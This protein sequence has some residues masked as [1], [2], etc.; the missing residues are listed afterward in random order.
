MRVSVHAAMRKARPVQDVPP[1][2]APGKTSSTCLER[3]AKNCQYTASSCSPCMVVRGSPCLQIKEAS[4][5]DEIL[6][7]F[8]SCPGAHWD[9][10]LYLVEGIQQAQQSQKALLCNLSSITSQAS[11]P[12]CCCTPLLLCS[13]L[14]TP[15]STSS[16]VQPLKH[17][18]PS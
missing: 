3:S 11:K 10:C 16:L 18:R 12:T 5:K 1:F 13:T 14:L 6:P 2:L 15:T 8:L 9:S 7:P 4:H 17:H